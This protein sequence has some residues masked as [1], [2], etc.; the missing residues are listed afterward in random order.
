MT[1]NA[2]LVKMDIAFGEQSS[3]A[4]VLVKYCK[5]ENEA[6]VNAIETQ[7]HGD[8]EW[9]SDFA[10]TELGGESR[11]KVI[12]IAEVAPEDIEILERYL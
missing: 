9:E 2:Y 11:I 12:S 3:M 5:S 6:S 4:K 1:S 7:I 8:P 10:C